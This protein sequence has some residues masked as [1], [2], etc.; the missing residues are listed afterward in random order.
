MLAIG[1]I[2]IRGKGSGIETDVQTAGIATYREGRLLHWKDFG[3]KEKAI[4][5]AGLP[6]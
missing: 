6:E 1:A 5:A 2:H 3:E 4:E